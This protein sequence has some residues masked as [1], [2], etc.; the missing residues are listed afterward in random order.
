MQNPQWLLCLVF[1]KPQIP[2]PG[3]PPRLPSGWILQKRPVAESIGNLREP[4]VSKEQ[5]FQKA[6]LRPFSSG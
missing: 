5:E 4:E 1:R 2:S 3:H 6:T